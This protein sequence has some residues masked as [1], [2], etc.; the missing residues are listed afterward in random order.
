MNSRQRRKA[1]RHTQAQA[2]TGRVATTTAAGMPASTPAPAGPAA[3]QAYGQILKSSS[4]MG[5]VAGFNLLLGMVRTKFAAVLIGTVGFGLI[6]NFGA[7]QGFVGTL[8]GLGIQSSAVREVAAAVASGDEEAIGRTVLTLRRLAWLTGLLG[9]ASMAALAPQ[10]SQWTF[11]HDG[12]TRDIAA[13][14]LIILFANLSGGQM[15]LIQGARRIGDMARANLA[16]AVLGTAVTLGCYLTWGLRG[17]VPALVLNAFVQLLLSWRFARRVPV[18]RVSMSWGQ[19]LRAGGGMV[20]LGVAMMWTGLLGSAAGYATNTLIT[21]TQGLPAVG[22]YSAAFS[23]SGM[24]I[25]F[26]LG[27]MGADYYPRLSGLVEDKPAM[28]RLVNQQTEVGL[29]LAVPGLLATLTLA[30][31]IVRLFLTPEFAYAA[32]LLQWLILGCLGRIISWPL[33]FVML[34]LGKGGW[35]FVTETAFQLLHLD[36]TLLGLAE[37]GLEGAA[38]AFFLL[39]VGY[40]AAMLWVGW[41]LIGFRWSRAC[42]EL[43]MLHLPLVALAFIG[44]RYLSLETATGAGIPLTLL[45]SLLCLRGLIHRVGHAAHYRHAPTLY[46]TLARQGL[47]V[48]EQAVAL[49]ISSYAAENP[50]EFVAET[51]ALLA[52]GAQ[53]IR[54]F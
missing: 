43:L 40:I 6:A 44:V 50:R 16:G 18:P 22:L 29:L 15:A 54:M 31:W 17:I 21:Q 35:Y 8:A 27:A 12:Y 42:L 45:T 7:I 38:V 51:F 14:G 4:I 1:A 3:S 46:T 34:A 33:G 52:A 13:L 36:L 53:S 26:V 37:F 28:V 11:G 2:L 5:G 47:S 49:K 19:N 10:L 32:D 20:R 24:F 23:L 9:M 30:P 39:Y 41:I 25:N 48:T